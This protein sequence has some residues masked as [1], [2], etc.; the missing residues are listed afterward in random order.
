MSVTAN[1]VVIYGAA[2]I[3]END[4]DVH[5]GAV[6]TAVRYIF[7]DAALVNSP[8]AS[9]GDGTLR[10]NST[11]N[12]DSAV[13]VIVTGRNVGGSIVSETGT[14]G[15]SG[16]VTTGT[17]V[18]ER[19]MKIVADTHSYNIEIDD[20]SSNEVVVIESGVTTVRRPFYNASSDPSAEKTY[21]EKV[22]V[23]NN[24]STHNLLGATFIDGGGDS[25]NYITFAL[26][27]GLPYNEI[28]ANRLAAPTGTGAG[29]FSAATKTLND[30]VG[31]P[32]LSAGDAVPVWLRMTLP[33]NAAAGKDTY[34]L[35]ISGSTI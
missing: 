26:P 3:A 7:G 23:K 4:S 18:F 27:N 32:D 16:V 11:N 1:D 5:G 34:T 35:Q 24:H 12:A 22:F 20:S 10:Y 30:N 8:I 31:S 29:G 14:L 21:Y 2:D 15:N 13:G 17:Q 25:N 9:G 28:L 33:L 6:A 19:I